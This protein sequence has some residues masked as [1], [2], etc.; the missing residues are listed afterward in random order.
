MEISSL[1]LPTSLM[2][3]EHTPPCCVLVFSSF[4][5]VQ[6][7]LCFFFFS[8]GQG[9]LQPRGLCWFIPGWL[10]EYCMMPGPHL[11]ICW[12]S[13]KQVWSQQ[14]VVRKLPCFICVIWHG[15]AFHGLGVQAAKVLMFFGALFLPS[16]APAFQ[17]C[18]W[19]T[20]LMLSASAP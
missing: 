15:E 19:F 1:S 3:L 14:L 9:V 5:I 10:G 18:F 4:F 8:A 17:Q 13:P 2:H 20:D 11:L 12:I 16:V 7:F 6:F